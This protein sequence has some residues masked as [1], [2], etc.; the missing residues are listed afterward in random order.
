MVS[1][2]WHG[3]MAKRLDTEAHGI[4]FLFNG[5][6]FRRRVRL[7]YEERFGRDDLWKRAGWAMG[8]GYLA[9]FLFVWSMITRHS[10]G[11]AS[12]VR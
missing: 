12:A 3:E 4:D 9:F 8:L 10:I 5:G 2:R 7:K 1:H 11:G 6:M